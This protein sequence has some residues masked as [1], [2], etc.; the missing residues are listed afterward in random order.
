M[1]GWELLLLED[2]CFPTEDVGWAAWGQISQPCLA[3]EPDLG[4]PSLGQKAEHPHSV[5]EVRC[6]LSRLRAGSGLNP[7]FI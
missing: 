6:V 4:A 5:R 3:F 7:P 2:I 1:L